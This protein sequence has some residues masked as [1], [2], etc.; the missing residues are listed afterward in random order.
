[1]ATQ[2]RIINIDGMTCG[3]CVASVH[4]ATGDIDGLDTMTVDLADKLATV[5]FD[6]SKTSAEAIAAAI[7]EAGFD[8]T[9]AN[10]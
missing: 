3:G 4:T 7:E 6:D 9:V 5:T 1:M 2:T 8:A 10:S